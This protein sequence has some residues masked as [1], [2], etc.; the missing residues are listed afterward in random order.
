MSIVVWVGSLLELA[1]LAGLV[2][3]R[4]LGQIRTLPLLLVATLASATT[5]VLC[6]PCNTWELWTAKE[7]SHLALLVILGFEVAQRAFTTTASQ[8]AAR[9]W[10]T[11]VLV[12]MFALA[13]AQRR[14]S[15]VVDVLPLLTSVVAWLYSGLAVIMLWHVGARIEPLH[16][17]V[18]SGFPPYLML[19]AAT[20]SQAADGTRVAGLVNPLV[21]LLV[22]AALLKAAWQRPRP[23]DVLCAPSMAEAMTFGR[24]T[25]CG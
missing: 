5:A 1:V 15:V 12:V 24:L 13:V 11:C 6:P 3:R 4:R 22:L 8:R 18:L 20:W 21:W 10:T 14:T 16:D 7:L 25:R 17:A 9:S 23:L 19:Y 2:V